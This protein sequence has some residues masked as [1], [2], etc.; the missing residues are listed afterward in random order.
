MAHEDVALSPAVPGFDPMQVDAYLRAHLSGLSGPM[1]LQPIAGGQSNPTYFVTYDRHRF[2]LRKKPGGVLLPSAHA[3]DREYRVMSALAQTVVPVPRMVLYCEDEQVIGTPFYLMD[4]LDGEVAHDAALP[5]VSP[6]RRQPLYQALARTLA[7]L[8]NVEPSAVGLGDYGRGG[9]YF[10]R[11]IARWTRQW[12]LSRT[13]EDA[14][15]Q[16]LIDWLPAHVPADDITAIAHGDYRVGNVMF[17]P[18]EPRVVGVLDWE[19]STLGH[20]LADLAHS[21]IAWHSEPSEYGGLRGLDL[22]RL[23]LPPQAEY[24]E[25]YYDAV[26][27]GLRMTAFH[28]AFALFRFSVIFEGIAARAKGGNAADANAGKTGLLSAS[29]ARRAVEALERA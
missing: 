4:R 21:C 2:V 14:N 25:A 10:S 28:M 27:H 19:L 17:H 8:H 23:G 20:P 18:V 9:N 15:V 5:T 11:Q 3:I 24:E 26:D 29:F 12:E 13:R 22:A 16:A 6:E 1:R 7:A